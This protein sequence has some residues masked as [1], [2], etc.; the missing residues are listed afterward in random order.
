MVHA[1]TRVLL[2]PLAGLYIKKIEGMENIPK[3]AA[4]LAA[5][6]SSYADD[7][8][9]PYIAYMRLRRRV[10]IFVNSRFYKNG[11]LSRFLLHF[12]CLP[13]DVRKDVADDKQRRATNDRAFKTALEGLRKGDL[14]GIFPEGSRSPD[15]KMRKAKNGV[16][17]MALLSGVP[18][19]PI[20]IG[21]SYEIMPK[22]KMFPRFRRAV[23]RVGE[24][25]A[26]GKE[27]DPE[28]ITSSI[29]KEIAKLSDQVYP[30]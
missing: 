21:G 2:G 28:K 14:F 16:A 26:F 15:G 1:L 11:L 27:K 5:N 10:W 20:G 22:G 12:D 17:R 3:G 24:P 7:V 23:I 8:F 9:L 13:V 6:H 19:V 18:V 4:I 25:M 30:W 29:M